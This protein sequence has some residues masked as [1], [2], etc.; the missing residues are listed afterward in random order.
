MTATAVH[1]SRLFTNTSTI[2]FTNQAVD[3]TTLSYYSEGQ[4]SQRVWKNTLGQTNRIQTYQWDGRGRL[5]RLTERDVNNNGHDW[6]AIYDALGRRSQTRTT[7]ITNNVAFTSQVK[8][9]S[10]IY[11]PLVEF[12]E[13]GVLADNRWSWKVYG[14]DLN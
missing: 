8:I 10:Q 7:P 3:Q 6:T 11:D 1:P 12:Q 4:L 5:Y 13:L 9:F 2:T 14:P